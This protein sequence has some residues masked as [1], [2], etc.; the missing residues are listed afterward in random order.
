MGRLLAIPLPPNLI[1]WEGCQLIIKG[2]KPTDGGFVAGTTIANVSIEAQL[3][4]G[5]AEDVG[6]PVLLLRP[7]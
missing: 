3:L 6:A 7:G 2:L 1:L 5:T 4:A